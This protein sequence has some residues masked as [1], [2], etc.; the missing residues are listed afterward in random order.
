MSDIFDGKCNKD[1]GF[2]LRLGGVGSG[3]KD[4]RNW[5]RYLVNGKEIQIS[6]EHGLKMQ[7]FPNNYFLSSS[8]RTS[9]KLLG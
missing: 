6:P 7:G 1:I 8:K 2:T 5:D 3:I 4:R 9:M